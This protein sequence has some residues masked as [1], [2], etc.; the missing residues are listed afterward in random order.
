MSQLADH[1]IATGSQV[2]LDVQDLTVDYWVPGGYRF[3]AVAGVDLSIRQG[4]ILAVVGES[5]SGKSSVALGVA[6]LLPHSASVRSEMLQINGIDCTDPQIRESHK[7]RG[8]EVGFVFQNPMSCLNPVYTVGEQVAEALCHHKNLSRKAA[9]SRTYEL[10][11]SVGLHQP[12]RIYPSFP[13]ELSGGMKQRVMIAIG[14]ACEPAL[15][16]A[17]EATTA[18]DVTVQAQVLDLLRQVVDE[19]NIGLL[20]ITHDLGVVE[21]IADRVA[22]MYGGRVVETAATET[23]FATPNHP[24]TQAL[25]RCS[26]DL[27]DASPDEDLHAIAGE[28]V[29]GA[30]S[31]ERCSFAPRCPLATSYCTAHRPPLSDIRH[32][33]DRHRS[34]C[35][36]NNPLLAAQLSQE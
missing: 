8:V 15:L 7:I 17:D 32:G 27:F 1:V 12:Q 24:Y 34:A 14:L 5:G 28:A 3:R 18:L 33:D 22:V 29:R 36:V 25:L 35:W 26:R 21:S 23:L 16:I 31:K 6:D 19:R 10:F 2:V 9:K 4:E 30:E 20:F 13:H 11:E